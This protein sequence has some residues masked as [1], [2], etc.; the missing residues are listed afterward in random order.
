MLTS[1]LFLLLSSSEVH[2]LKLDKI[3]KVIINLAGRQ[4]GTLS[5]WVHGC[6]IFIFLFPF[7]QWQGTIYFYNCIEIFC[8]CSQRSSLVGIFS[9]YY[10]AA[11]AQCFYS[12]TRVQSS[13]KKKTALSKSTVQDAGS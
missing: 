5:D 11:V 1:E 10:D 4:T 8:G 6:S 7:D 9:L 13:R 2:C 3:A 12:Y